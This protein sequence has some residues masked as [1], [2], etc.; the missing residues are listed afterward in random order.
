LTAAANTERAPPMGARSEGTGQRLKWPLLF[1]LPAAVVIGFFFFTMSIMARISV[2][3][4]LG[5][6]QIGDGFTLDNYFQFFSSTFHLSYLFRSLWIAAYCTAITAVL[7]YTI[8]YF[9]HRSGHR[10]RVIVGTLLIIQFFTA[11]VIR[12]YAVML[13]IGKT[14]ILNRSLIGAGIIEHPLSLLFTEAGVAIGMVL[15]S[16]PFMVFPIVASLQSIPP[17]VEMAAASLGASNTRIFWTVI[18]PLTMP[19]ITAGVV[20]V[21]LFELTSYIV[22]GVLGGG[23]VDMIA[24]LIYAKAMQSFDHPFAAAAA[25]VTLL[26]SGLTIY[27]LQKAFRL[28]TPRT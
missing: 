17:N 28:A 26:I 5:P 3:P 25:M 14:G 27:L 13:V 24:N 1:L 22:P 2:A 12:T 10:T 8:A 21:Y 18:V 23:Y 20:V 19:G 11:Y 16:L 7:G 15:V 6:A 9:I 4:N